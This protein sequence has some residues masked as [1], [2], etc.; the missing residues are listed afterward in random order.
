M[1][2]KILNSLLLILACQVSGWGQDKKQPD[3]VGKETPSEVQL[4]KKLVKKVYSFQQFKHESI[5][6]VKQPTK[7]KSKNWLTLGAVVVGTAAV[8][9]FDERIAAASQGNQQS[10]AHQMSQLPTHHET[11]ILRYPPLTAREP[12]IHHTPES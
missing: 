3:V 1:L 9:P 2:Q 12:L 8:M 4:E 7:W 6:F 11:F 10:N 5:L